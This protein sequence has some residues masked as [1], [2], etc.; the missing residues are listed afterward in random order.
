MTSFD[1]PRIAFSYRFKVPA[2]GGGGG[3]SP[4]RPLVR[5][6]Q[7]NTISGAVID[8]SSSTPFLAIY[9]RVTYISWSFCDDS[10]VT[11]ITMMV[12]IIIVMM[13]VMVIMITNPMP[14]CL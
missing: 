13:L 1:Q 11:I 3:G 9:V 5:S 10:M 8:F 14:T 7:I 2:F 12:M 4:S 6:S